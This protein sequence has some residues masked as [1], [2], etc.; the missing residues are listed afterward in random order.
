MSGTM[1]LL[2]VAFLA[3]LVVGV[4][5]TTE[6]PCSYHGATKPHITLV[7][8]SVVTLEGSGSIGGCPRAT[9][10]AVPRLRLTVCLQHLGASG[11]VDVACRGPVFKSWSRY[12]RFARQVGLTV[13][14]TCKPG[15][16]RTIARGGDGLPPLKWTSAAAKFASSDQYACGEPGGA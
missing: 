11:W 3:S 15:L 2:A 1:L 16:W 14:A 6:Q 12:T 5:T 4:N 8:N 9:P 13:T 7:N 10:T